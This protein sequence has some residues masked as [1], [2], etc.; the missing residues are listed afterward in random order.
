MF[1]KNEISGEEILLL[2]ILLTYNAIRIADSVFAKH[3]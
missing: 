2:N 1:I 3:F